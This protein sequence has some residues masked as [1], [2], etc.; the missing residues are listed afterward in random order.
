M[1]EEAGISPVHDQGET[2]KKKKK[3]PRCISFAIFATITGVRP[4]LAAADTLLMLGDKDSHM[5]M[6]S[7]V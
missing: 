3:K 7:E 5:H 1:N 2:I 4:I 6:H